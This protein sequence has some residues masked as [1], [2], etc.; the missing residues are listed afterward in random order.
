MWGPKCE[1]VRMPRVL[2]A[3]EALSLSTRISDEGRREREGL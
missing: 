1:K 2:P 3:G